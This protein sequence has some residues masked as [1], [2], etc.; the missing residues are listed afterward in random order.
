MMDTFNI[1]GPGTDYWDSFIWLQGRRQV[2]N[3]DETCGLTL[4]STSTVTVALLWQV[5]QMFNI[6]VRAVFF[7]WDG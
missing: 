6:H 3:L 5:Y 2:R 1:R 4:V 7:F